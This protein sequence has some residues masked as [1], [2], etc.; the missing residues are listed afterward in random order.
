MEGK[1]KNSIENTRLNKSKVFEKRA[2]LAKH[3]VF[4]NNPDDRYLTFN[5][6][7]NFF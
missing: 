5:A 6:I 4:Q 2:N 3:N 7:W 1:K